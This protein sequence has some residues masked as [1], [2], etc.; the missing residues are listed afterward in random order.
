[1]IVRF[2]KQQLEDWFTGNF[3][4]KQP[5]NSEV[6]KQYRKVVNQLAAAPN[7]ATL[8]TIKGLNLHELKRELAGKYAVRVNKQYRIV[9]IWTKNG[10]LEIVE[11][12]D[13][14]DYH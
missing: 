3:T 2:T 1:M 12:D 10:M 11:I 6:L 5:F 9:F 8:R 13:L 4:G 7:L 14:T